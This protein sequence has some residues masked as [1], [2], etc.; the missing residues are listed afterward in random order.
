MRTP[1]PTLEGLTARTDIAQL[2]DHMGEQLLDLLMLVRDTVMEH[3]PTVRTNHKGHHM[4]PRGVSQSRK[5]IKEKRKQIAR[6]IHHNDPQLLTA[7]VLKARLE[8]QQEEAPHQTP[9]Q[10]LKAMKR[11]LSKEL[12]MLDREHT[13]IYEQERIRKL[14]ALFDTKQK[15]GNKIMTG[16]YKGRNNAALHAIHTDYGLET[17][18]HQL[19]AYTEHYFTKKMVPATGVKTGEY[20]PGRQPRRYPCSGRCPGPVPPRHCYDQ[21]QDKSGLAPHPPPRQ[22]RLHGLSQDPVTRQSSWP[23]RSDQ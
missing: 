5:K 15:I 12:Q 13:T 2:I 8:E 23:R 3:G 19:I 22:P 17:R 1:I 10:I 7:P 21:G 18:P 9:E 6:A 20:E 11:E 14:R 4:Y 16:Q